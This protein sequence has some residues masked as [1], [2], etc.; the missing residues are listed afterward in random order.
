MSDLFYNPLFVYITVA[1]IVMTLSYLHA[2]RILKFLY[3]RTLGQRESL[4]LLLDQL[5][6]ET[7]RKKLTISL[8]LLSFG[9]G[10]IA[11]LAFWPNL[12][13]GLIFAVGLSI[14]GWTIPKMILQNMWEKRCDR[15]VNQ[16]VDGLTIMANSI[17]A[18]LSVTQGMERVVENIRGP[19]S[20]EFSLALNKV[21]LGAPVEQALTEFSD[22]IPR[23]DVQM[24]VTGVN[25]L[26]ETGGNM[27]ETFETISTTVRERQ[28]IERRIEAMMAQNKMQAIIISVVPFGLLTFMGITN[29]TNVAPLF[30]TPLGWF[31]LFLML[32]LQ[33]IGGVTMKKIVNIKI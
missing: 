18:G 15:I 25:I 22:R 17:R 30:T 9:L 13:I 28:K 3:Q 14:A 7:D 27:A 19:L 32:T 12:I 2:D 20:Q 11:F 10:F 5:Y 16:M 31:L 33:V 1:L 26:K 29:P 4:Y 24:F 21:R 23:P 6:V 8:Y